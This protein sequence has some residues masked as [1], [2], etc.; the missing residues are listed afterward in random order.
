MTTLNMLGKPC[1][2][3][4]VEAKKIL[5]QGQD[6][7]VLVDNNIAV[8][9]LEKMAAGLGHDFSFEQKGEAE[10]AVVII[11]KNS[12]AGPASC[13]AAAPT[14]RPETA[15]SEFS[16]C[17][18]RQVFLIT[19]DQIGISAEEAGKKLMQTFLYS[20]AQ[21]PK[22]PEIILLINAGVKLAAQGS[23]VLDNLK[24][25]AE[26]GADI[27]SC[28][29]CLNYYGLTEKLAVGKITNMMEIVEFL[30]SSRRVITI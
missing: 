9:N 18:S 29:Q 10:Y 24:A 27:R 7:T 20:L 14:A 21:L 12:A 26:H 15:P 5:L 16:P 1:P 6:V 22:A 30:T 25:L 3:P 2:I 13:Q 28:G 8:Q 4:V 11:V 23:D 19:G 17:D